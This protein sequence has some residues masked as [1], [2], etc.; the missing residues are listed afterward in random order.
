MIEV[1]P[2]LF[3]GNGEN[4][5]QGNTKL[6][7]VHACKY[8]CHQNAVGYRGNLPSTHP[9]YLVLE[10]KFNLYLNMIDPDKPLFMPPLFS[11][12]LEFSKKHWNQG[13]SILIHCNRGESRSPTLA[14]MFMSKV[15]FVLPNDSFINAKKEFTS[16][17]PRY[18]P[19]L[20]IQI[21][22]NN[23]WDEF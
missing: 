22:L 12:F 19:V 1:H 5:I 10:D 13:K 7:V 2:N 8:P 17:Y 6:V 20:G 9:N 14:M 15:L 4:C 18:Q 23:N 11:R 21:Y 16:L 3:V